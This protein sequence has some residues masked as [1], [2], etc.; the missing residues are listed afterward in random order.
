M[1]VVILQSNY[2]PWRGYFDLLRQADLFVF[3]DDLQYTKQDW[4]NRN[5][6]KTPKGPEWLSIPVGTSEGRL[7]C[8]VTLPSDQ[9]WQAEH[10]RKI[11][12]AYKKHTPCFENLLP[13]LKE[14]YEKKWANLSEFNQSI[15]KC[16]TKDYL[17]IKHVKFLDSRNLN[18]TE[19]KQM[20][21]LQ[22]LEKVN[23]KHYVSGPAAKDYLE[24]EEFKKRNILL[25][26]MRYEYPDYDQPH[27][28]FS[29][30]VSIL[31]TLTCLTEDQWEEYTTSKATLE[32][33][34]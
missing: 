13:L 1:K 12:Q 9:K 2:I 16:I 32:S 19:K 10:Y 5:K 22:I 11:E 24:P 15:I 27:G 25:S 18:L 21:V 8:N 17:N 26:Y 6:I 23:A 30:Q 14:I 4:R 3:H 28:S 7:I 29:P 33:A 31:D 20:R 34:T